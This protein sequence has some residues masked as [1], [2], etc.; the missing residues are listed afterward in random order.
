MPVTHELDI[1]V[2]ESVVSAVDWE[3]DLSLKAIPLQVDIARTLRLNA[4]WTRALT[5]SAST[6]D[7]V[8]SLWS[9]VEKLL[10][11][12]F[13]VVT[14]RTSTIA[15]LSTRAAAYSLVYCFRSGDDVV[16][17]RGFAPAVVLPDVARDFGVD[18]RPLYSVH[19][20]FVHLLSNDGGPLPTSQWRYVVDPVT[21]QASLVKIAMDGSEAFGF[22]VSEQPAKSYVVRPVDEEVEEVDAW[23]F[24]DDLMAC[25]LEDL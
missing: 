8:K 12:T 1:K 21:G 6:K 19:D 2:V 7:R 20:G 15:L 16:A 17:R 11:R 5:G 23:Q 13:E 4:E 3:G 18:L 10:P 22:D 25:R 9:G 14:T 24:L